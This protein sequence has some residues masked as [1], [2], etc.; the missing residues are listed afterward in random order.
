MSMSTWWRRW[1]ATATIGR[2]RRRAAHVMV[3]PLIHNRF[4]IIIATLVISWTSIVSFTSIVPLSGRTGGPTITAA[5]FTRTMAVTVGVY[6]SI[7]WWYPRRSRSWGVIHLLLWYHCWS[8]S[9][10]YCRRRR[11][12]CAGRCWGFWS[13]HKFLCIDVEIK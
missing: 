5:H 7:L 1:V 12:R 11:W 6:W 9:C 4:P 8:W 3:S 2:V 10:N 13:E